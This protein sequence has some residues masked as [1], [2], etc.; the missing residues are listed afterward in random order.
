MGFDDM[1]KVALKPTILTK[2]VI[3]K[4]FG[5]A[6]RLITDKTYSD[7]PFCVEYSP[8]T[9]DSTSIIYIEDSFTC[10]GGSVGMSDSYFKT[11]E[12][13]QEFFNDIIHQDKDFM[14]KKY[15]KLWVE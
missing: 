5:I 10:F 15:P 7:R 13:A 12:Q 4:K 1:D 8:L 11:L 9:A 6:I 14:L 3:V 2:S